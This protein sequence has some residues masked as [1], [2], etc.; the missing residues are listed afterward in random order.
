MNP[1]VI[2]TVQSTGTNNKF[3]LGINM[4]D[5]INIFKNRG[6]C[7]FIIIEK[8][9]FCCKTSCGP[10]PKKSFDLYSKE[11]SDWIIMNRFHIYTYN[12]PKKLLFNIT[13]T[14]LFLKLEFVDE[15][16]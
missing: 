8:D 6:K 5:S 11:L 4:E 13:E 15:I 2:L 9:H 12:N 10:P 16:F 14:N 7:V 3:R 1:T